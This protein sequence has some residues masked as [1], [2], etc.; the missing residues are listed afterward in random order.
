MLFRTSKSFQIIFKCLNHLEH[1]YVLKRINWCHNRYACTGKKL[2]KSSKYEIKNKPLKCIRKSIHSRLKLNEHCFVNDLANA[3]SIATHLCEDW[4]DGYVFEIN[5]GPGNL[6]R[7]IL[8]LGVP[9]LRVF[10]KNEEFFPLL[11]DISKEYSNF[12]VIED[13]FFSLPSLE[14]A[15]DY[16]S[17]NGW[18]NFFHNIPQLFWKDGVP[19]RIFSIIYS[20]K[21]IKFLRYLLAALSNQATIFSYGRCEL[22]FLL[23]Q[24]EYSYLTAEPKE[25][26]A[27]Y[28]WST[29]LYKIFFEIKFLNKFTPDIISPTPP[30]SSKK[31][32]NGHYFYFVRLT[33]RLDLFSSLVNDNKLQDFY[34]FIKH[35]LVRR[36][37]LVIPVMEGWVPLC[38]PRLIKEGMNVYTRFGDLSP[39]Q[40]LMLFN[41]FS[42]WPEYEESVFQLSMKK[43]QMRRSSVLFDDDES[44]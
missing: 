21:S 39:E 2:S 12:E 20:K 28:R 37:G 13:D 4:K 9:H 22:F 26:F 35:N 27:M 17:K 8:K 34:F 33:P 15:A 29:V 40:L 31:M 14:R 42:S 16:T 44:S 5:P 38:G 30:I 11:M 3:D 41:Q 32:K 24:L 7:A 6:S 1:F 25:N 18:N 10:E 19:F 23:P 43:F 36:S